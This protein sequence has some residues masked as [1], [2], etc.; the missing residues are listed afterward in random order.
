M[1]TKAA[2][3]DQIAALQATLAGE[4]AAVWGYALLGPRLDTEQAAWARRS[5]ESHRALRD[6]WEAVLLDLDT[7]PEAARPA[8]ELP[9][10]VD[11]SA[12]ARRLARHLEDGCAAVYADLVA[13]ATSAEIRV[14]A[15]DELAECVLR[16]IDWGADLSAFP[17]LPER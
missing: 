6:K 8:Y 9:F 11:D 13:A 12:A 10:P 14:A 7:E 15:A 5:Y 17:G 4:H 1:T 3:A 16:A 2:R